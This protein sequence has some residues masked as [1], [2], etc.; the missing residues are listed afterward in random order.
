MFLNVGSVCPPIQKEGRSQSYLDHWELNQ[1][2]WLCHLVNYELPPWTKN[3]IIFNA[4]LAFLH[5]DFLEAKQ[6]KF[7]GWGL[8]SGP[9]EQHDRPVLVLIPCG[10]RTAMIY[11]SS[12]AMSSFSSV[13]GWVILL[14]RMRI[15][16]SKVKYKCFLWKT[17]PVRD[18]GEIQ[19]GLCFSVNVSHL[20]CLKQYVKWNTP[21]HSDFTMQYASKIMHTQ[22]CMCYSICLFLHILQCM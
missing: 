7:F 3:S 17:I 8:P 11:Y 21:V 4:I 9:L 22:M 2:I 1:H 19:T 18:R 14:D 12:I 6:I 15:N 13:T 20:C 16:I 5:R 10:M